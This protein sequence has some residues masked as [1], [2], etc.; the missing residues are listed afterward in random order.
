MSVT[1]RETLRLFGSGLAAT[2]VSLRDGHHDSLPADKLWI[3]LA[4][5]NCWAQCQ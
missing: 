3:E 1:R 2:A 4:S 5:C